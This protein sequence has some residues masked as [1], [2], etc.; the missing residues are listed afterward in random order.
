M[1]EKYQEE[2]EGKYLRVNILCH[3]LMLSLALIDSTDH[4]AATVSKKIYQLN[5]VFC[6]DTKRQRKNKFQSLVK[7]AK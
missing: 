5:N 2:T 4:Q 7:K 1:I 3:M 6:T